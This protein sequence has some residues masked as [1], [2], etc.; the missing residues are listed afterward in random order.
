MRGVIEM[1]CRKKEWS[2]EEIE[3]NLKKSQEWVERGIVAI[4]NLQTQEEKSKG[5]TKDNNGVGFNGI[6]SEFMSSL[7]EWIKSDKKLS[8]KQLKFGREK[9]MKYAGQLTKIANGEI[10]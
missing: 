8:A 4:W 1:G 2:R 5:Y 6:D 3:E 7:A 10:E 9:L